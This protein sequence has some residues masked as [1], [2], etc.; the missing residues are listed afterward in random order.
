MQRYRT[1]TSS[2]V[3][4]LWWSGGVY[5]VS[6]KVVR[7]IR[8]AV[9]AETFKLCCMLR[10]HATGTKA[11]SVK[12]LENRKGEHKGA[13]NIIL[14]VSQTLSW[15]CRSFLHQRGTKI[16]RKTYT[17]EWPAPFSHLFLLPQRPGPVEWL[18]SAS[19]RGTCL[20]SLC[21]GPWSFARCPARPTEDARLCLFD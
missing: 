6:Q 7:F 9:E 20:P 17:F 10:V 4:H 13:S 15:P 12:V 19:L 18:F 1:R 8:A 16:M 21:R 2:C 11:L 14:T 5:Q 3:Y